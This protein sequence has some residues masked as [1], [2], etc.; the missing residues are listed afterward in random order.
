MALRLT[1]GGH[2]E[3]PL[4]LPSELEPRPFVELACEIVQAET[5]E[6]NDNP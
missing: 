1:K 5:H 6:K 3:H 4:Y 2:P